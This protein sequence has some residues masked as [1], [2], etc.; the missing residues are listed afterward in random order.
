MARSMRFKPIDKEILVRPG[1]ALDMKGAAQFVANVARKAISDAERSNEAAL[2]RVP[3][4]E[5]FVNGA[6]SDRFDDVRPGGSIV[7]QF[8]LGIEVV[9]FVYD[10]CRKNAPALDGDFRASI[11][12]YADGA[13]VDGPEEARGAREVIVTSIVPYA[14]KIERGQSKQAPDGVFEGA[15]VLAAARFGNTATVRFTYASPT[16]GINKLERWALKNAGR[17]RNPKR[18][19]ARNT[20]Q[21]AIIIAM[22]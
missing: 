5:T 11:R 4:K 9:R 20:R 1:G 21:P 17:T 15:A 12:V 8:D 19:Y 18:Q 3:P 2:G 13:E 22:K 10:L 6:A 14:R 7:A 16:G